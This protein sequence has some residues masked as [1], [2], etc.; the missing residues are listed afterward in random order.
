ME[1]TPPSV[2]INIVQNIYLHPNIQ[3]IQNN[4]Y[5]PKY[6]NTWRRAS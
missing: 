1:H 5:M 6:A 3:S 4:K 2:I